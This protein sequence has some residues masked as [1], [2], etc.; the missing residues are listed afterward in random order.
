MLDA[1]ALGVQ[2]PRQDVCLG[3]AEQRLPTVDEGGVLQVELLENRVRP[4]PLCFGGRHSRLHRTVTL[5]DERGQLVAALISA[6]ELLPP[7]IAGREAKR[8]DVQRDVRLSRV[9]ISRVVCGFEIHSRNGPLQ[10]LV[11]P[12]CCEIRSSAAGAHGKLVLAQVA[13]AC[14]REIRRLHDVGHLRLQHDHHPNRSKVSRH[15]PLQGRQHFGDP[16]LLGLHSILRVA[17]H[18]LI[19]AGVAPQKCRL[20][21]LLP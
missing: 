18:R 2:K 1:T 21:R 14:D 15:L 11:Q 20:Q 8:T 17:L 19:D 10:V 16:L 13:E 5:R 12:D 9:G 3:G 4:L 6:G 7:E